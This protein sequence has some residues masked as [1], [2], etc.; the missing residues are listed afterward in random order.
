MVAMLLFAVGGGLSVYEG[1]V[2]IRHPEPIRDPIWNYAVLGIAFLAEGASWY[3]ALRAMLKER[4][5]GESYFRTF[6]A[7]KDP[8]VFIVLAEDSA[9]LL[10]IVSAFL[11]VLLAVTLDMPELDGVA[12]LV[13]G[14]ILIAVASLLVY[15]T[16]ALMMGEGA[17]RDLVGSVRSIAMSEALVTGVPKLLTMYLGPRHIL[18]NMDVQ[19]EP[20]ISSDALF[21]TID[22]VE[23]NIRAAHPDVRNIFVEVEAFRSTAE[24]KQGRASS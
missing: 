16:R 22:R 3:I 15:E 24:N 8:A 14:A 10:G 1:I 13:I 11:G 6:R 4:K 23:S 21:E 12:S 9:A 7:S 2:H 17:D 19:F 20:A 5:P 18:L